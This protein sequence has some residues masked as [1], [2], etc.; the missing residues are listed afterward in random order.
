MNLEQSDFINALILS[1]F[2]I[3]NIV[4]KQFLL[5]VIK[6]EFI[7][8]LYIAYIKN[9][10]TISIMGIGQSVSLPMEQRSYLEEEDGTVIDQPD[11]ELE[12]APR[13]FRIHVPSFVPQPNPHIRNLLENHMMNPN[14]V[15]R[16][17]TILNLQMSMHPKTLVSML[18]LLM[19]M[20][21]RNGVYGDPHMNKNKCNSDNLSLN[22]LLNSVSV[23]PYAMFHVQCRLAQV[24]SVMGF[25]QEPAEN[26][27]CDTPL[28]SCGET[29]A[30]MTDYMRRLDEL[31]NPPASSK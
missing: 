14:M 20:V 19:G 2:S 9:H 11:W 5:I 12:P 15:N 3:N 28:P 1:S 4:Y 26:T 10:G 23:Y 30:T 8:M 31:L 22:D 29:G 21:T 18:M 17:M 25:V 7:Y 24:C 27:E 6:I 16:V 13:L